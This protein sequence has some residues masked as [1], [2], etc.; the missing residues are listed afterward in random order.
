MN[1]SGNTHLRTPRGAERLYV[2]AAHRHKRLVGRIDEIVS[3]WGYLP[4]Q[5]PVFDFYDVYQALLNE[6]S[7][8]DVYRLVDREGDVLMLRSDV[9][10]FL[11]KQ[12]GMSLTH[13]ELPVRVAYADT[14]L[15]HQD[16]E[17]ISRNEFFQ[18][19][20]ELIG[21]P[22]LDGDL[23]VIVLLRELL[24]GIGLTD[25]VIHLGSRQL[26]DSMSTVFAREIG[27]SFLEAVEERSWP[28]VREILST[29]FDESAAARR[30]ELL[31]FIGSWDEF[32]REQRA[33]LDKLSPAEADAIAYLSSVG[34][35][36][37]DVSELREIRVDLS[38]IGSQP[39]HTGIVFRAYVD[40]LDSAAATGGRYDALLEQFGFPAPSVGFS[41]LVRK[42][43]EIAVID[44]DENPPTIATADGEDFRARLASARTLRATGRIATV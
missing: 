18:T 20:V 7:A 39:Y 15:R 6:R 14:I 29:A 40:G 34:S 24:D 16:E 9:T 44:G 25:A 17:D 12:M 37:R 2:D 19:G 30:T 26:V 27:L 4:V 35:L 43:D 31:S 21:V 38:E 8:K 1:R 13:A 41:V 3:S 22:G 5:T 33:H 36:A 23:E 42:I 11:A 28:D 10:L 32:E